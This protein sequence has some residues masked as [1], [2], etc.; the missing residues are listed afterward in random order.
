ME[1]GCVFE[2]SWSTCTPSV[3][4]MWN[5][6]HRERRGEADLEL[7]HFGLQIEAV[8]R[9]GFDQGCTCTEHAV[10]ARDKQRAQLL[11]RCRACVTDCVSDAT[12]C[13]KRVII[14]RRGNSTDPFCECPCM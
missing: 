1:I 3:G 9:L 8:A 10:E 4:D 2:T 7:L 14:Q 5:E 11:G 6:K 12:T 13:A